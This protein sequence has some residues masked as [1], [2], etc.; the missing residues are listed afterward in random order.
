MLRHLLGEK[1]ISGLTQSWILHLVILTRQATCAVGAMAAR[2]VMGN[3][4]LFDWV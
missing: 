2:Q 4:P 1:D 3:E